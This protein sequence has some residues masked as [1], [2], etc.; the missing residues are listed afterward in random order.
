MNDNHTTGIRDLPANSTA[1]FTVTDTYAWDDLRDEYIIDSSGANSPTI[2]VFGANIEDYGFD[3]TD[4]VRTRLHIMHND[5]IGGDKRLH[6]H[7][8]IAPDA[9]APGATD[10]VLSH[11]VSHSYGSIGIGETRGA[12][13]AAIVLIQTI[14][15]AE[16]NAIGS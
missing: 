2:E 10:L 16:I 12:S 4:I 11:T 8:F 15:V 5:V 3:A 13:P 14:T 1:G 6:P 9:I 7:V